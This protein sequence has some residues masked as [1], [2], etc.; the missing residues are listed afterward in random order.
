M[1]EAPIDTFIALLE[2][3][4]ADASF[5]KLVL[6]KPRAAAGDRVRVSVRPVTLKGEAQLS[7]VH[8]H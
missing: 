2:R 8:T 7:F 5:A 1:D 6:A 4:L 3:A